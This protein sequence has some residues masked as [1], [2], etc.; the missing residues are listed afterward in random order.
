MKSHK[1]HSCS[2]LCVVARGDQP[3]PGAEGTCT[4]AC[5]SAWQGA[6]MLCSWAGATSGLST[7]VPELAALRVTR[8]EAGCGDAPAQPHAARLELAASQRKPASIPACLCR[9]TLNNCYCF[10]EQ[11][12]GL[13]CIFT[14]LAGG[15]AGALIDEEK[16]LLALQ[17]IYV[18]VPLSAQEILHAVPRGWHPQPAADRAH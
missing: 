18:T 5:M 1:F 12:S 7:A 15:T 14:C 13:C 10:P 17:G 2:V 11:V 9:R 3:P 16:G 8:C 4:R 6:S